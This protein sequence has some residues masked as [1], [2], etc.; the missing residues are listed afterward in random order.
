MDKRIAGTDGANTPAGGVFRGALS[1]F[2]AWVQ[3]MLGINGN[4]IMA[5]RDAMTAATTQQGK[6]SPQGQYVAIVGE[7]IL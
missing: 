3:P 6:E 1:R 2:V 5:A 4:K 7:C